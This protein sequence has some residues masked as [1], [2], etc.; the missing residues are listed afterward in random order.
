[1]KFTKEEKSTLID[2]LNYNRA[3]FER[4]YNKHPSD[5]CTM[6]IEKIDELISKL[7]TLI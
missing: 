1:M 4:M 7:K 2:A 5:Y 6:Q 3:S